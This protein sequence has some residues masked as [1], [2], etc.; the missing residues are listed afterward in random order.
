MKNFS[1]LALFVSYILILCFVFYYPKFNKQGT[2]ATISYDVAGYYFYLPAIFIYQDIH[3]LKFQEELN[4]KY[5]FAPTE[6]QGVLLPDSTFTMKYPIGASVFYSPFFFIAHGYASLTGTNADGFSYPYQVMLSLGCLFYA[7][8]GLWFLRKIL[9]FYFSETATGI[10]LLLLVAATNYL[11]YS[12]IDNAM[13]HNLL[14]TLYVFII[15]FSIKFHKNPSF[16]I[17]LLLGIFCGLATITRPTEIIC[18]FI[19]LLWNVTGYTGFVFR[20]KFFLN[21]YKR[22]LAFIFGAIL[23]GSLQMIYWKITTGKFLFYSYEEQSFSWLNPHLEDGL[24]SYKK[25]WFVYTPFLLLIIPGF[26]YLYKKQRSIYLPLFLFTIVNIYIVFSW[27]IWWYGGSLG[28][29]SM[30]QSYVLLSFPIA[31]LIHQILES[32]KV[33]KLVF[34]LF[35]AFCIWYNI[36]LTFQAHNKYGVLHSESMNRTYFWT[37]FGKLK[38]ELD[39]KKYIDT[40]EKYRGSK[41][42]VQEIYFN[43]IEFDLTDIDTNRVISGKKCLFV[44][45]E[46]QFTQ[47]YTIPI[48]SDNAKWLNISAN[49]YF[50]QK[51]WDVWKMPQFVVQFKN[52][53]EPIKTKFI[54]IHR[55]MNSGEK[56]NL[57][58]D[59]ELPKKE[60]NSIEFYLWNADG[61]TTTYMDNV[62]VMS[63]Q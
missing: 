55:I 32:K 13:T 22:S 4:K 14:F 3:H 46:K 17:A 62:R 44:S 25:G 27:D 42:N 58:F 29:R 20:L 10:T 56:R 53:N 11:N 45:A 60:Y 52:K 31:A 19:P 61:T 18:V 34:I 54:R 1:F 24:F 21:Q 12:A 7:F 15:W 9:L 43:D 41:T 2:E 6:Y 59:I 8:L 51:Q 40:N 5:R 47:P 30:V 50:P 63:F 39:D 16:K 37:V 57:N 23:V 36:T 48:P 38:I 49:F 28:Q 35:S 33:F 26:I